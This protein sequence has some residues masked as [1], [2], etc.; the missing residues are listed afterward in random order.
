MELTLQRQRC[1]FGWRRYLCQSAA[2]PQWNMEHGPTM[3]SLLLRLR[4]NEVLLE[5][6]EFVTVDTALEHI[7][8]RSTEC[9]QVI[10]HS[11]SHVSQ[12][13][14]ERM[15][16]EKADDADARRRA[17]QARQAAILADFAKQQ[18]AFMLQNFGSDSDESEEEFEGHEDVHGGGGR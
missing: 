11:E 13:D 4:E 8:M 1:G 14:S 15:A 12:A 17:A 2:Q 10:A 9:A 5:S 16:D 6:L 7:R 18:Q 3:L